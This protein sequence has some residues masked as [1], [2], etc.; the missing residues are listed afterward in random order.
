[1]RSAWHGRPSAVW[2]ALSADKDQ[3]SCV[4][5][6]LETQWKVTLR[7]RVYPA[8][9]TGGISAASKRWLLVDRRA[10]VDLDVGS[11]V[12]CRRRCC[13][14]DSGFDLGS[15]RHKRLLNVGCILRACLQEWN[16]QLVGVFLQSPNTGNIVMPRS[17]YARNIRLHLHFYR[18]TLCWRVY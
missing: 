12:G 16:A 18:A 9:R 7:T 5:V 4:R 1:M 2:T 17:W 13:R 15:H 14:P 11:W 10:G 8:S 3:S 6:S